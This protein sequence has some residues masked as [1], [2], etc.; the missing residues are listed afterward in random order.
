LKRVAYLEKSFKT[1]IN[2]RQFENI[3]AF[4]KPKMK[5]MKPKENEL[6]WAEISMM[7]AIQQESFY[8]DLKILKEKDIRKPLSRKEL[9]KI[10]SPLV[11][12]N[13][14]LMIMK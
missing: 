11:S 7:K 12:L 4:Y 3:G 9:K 13:P 1:L 10:S 5:D 2:K 6:E 8:G 14:F